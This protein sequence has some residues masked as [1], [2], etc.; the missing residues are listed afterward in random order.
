M[1]PTPDD[2]I[3]E[4][5]SWKGTPFAHLQRCKGAGVDCGQYLIAVYHAVGLIPEV[6]VGYY[7]RDF[8][9]HNDREWYKELVE[10]F[11]VEVPPPPKPA[12]VAL[13]RFPDGKVFH[14]GGI[15]LDWPWIIHAF[16]GVGVG[17]VETHGE[18]GRLWGLPVK[19]FR[20]K[21]FV[22]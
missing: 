6:E 17:V 19:F 14:H 15:V 11:A 18:Q 8:H 10:Q 12:D 1:V 4:A 21:A 9:R 22:E 3:K 5:L 2:V 16:R 7:P 13:Y 20:P